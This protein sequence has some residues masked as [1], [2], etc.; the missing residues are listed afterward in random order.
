MGYSTMDARGLIKIVSIMNFLQDTA[1]EHA[2]RLGV[3][4]IY[5]A[6]QNFAW[7]IYRYRI[8]IHSYPR[9]LETVAVSTHRH[10]WKN[11][12]EIREIHMGKKGRKTPFVTSRMAWVMVN[13]KNQRPVRLDRYLPRE[14]L[15]QSLTQDPFPPPLQPC[16]RVDFELFFKVRMHDLDLNDHVNNA[17]YVEWAVETLP[18]EILEKFRPGTIDVTFQKQAFYGDIIVSRTQITFQDALPMTVHTIARGADQGILATLHVTWKD[19][20]N[21]EKTQPH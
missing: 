14:M 17:I 9:W 6:R 3:S 2:H 12:Y 7:V 10:A 4:G 16:E 18:R 19:R 13:K 20:R 11:L 1:S 15:A 21:D 5:L 8:E